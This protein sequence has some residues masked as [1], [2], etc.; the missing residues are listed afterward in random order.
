MEVSLLRLIVEELD[1]SRPSALVTV[2]ETK[3]S[4]PR[5]AGSAM[6]VRGDASIA[7]TVGGGRGEALAREA[8]QAVIESGRSRMI[9]VEML[10]EATLGSDMICG[11]TSGM[12]VEFVADRRTYGAAL[13]AA[14][15][16][17]R[18]LVLRSLCSEPFG[19]PFD[20]EPLLLD[21]ALAPRT[22]PALAF[23]R[24]LAESVLRSRKPSRDEEGRL[25]YDPL[26]PEEK[27]LILGGGHVGRA[28][29][30]LAVNLEFKVSV[31]D[32]RPEFVEASRF[33]GS[34][35]T[36]AGS[37]SEIVSSF[38]FDA[39][40]YTVI[41]T[42]GHLLD[43]ECVRAVLPKP[44][45]Y[46]GFIGSARK[47]RMILEQ[48]GT[49]GFD[50]VKVGALHAPIGLDIGAESPEEIAVSILA[51]IIAVRHDSTSGASLAEAR[52]ARRS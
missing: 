52:S 39:S 2:V 4:V 46:V 41:M 10:G 5:H 30:Q 25:F 3:G 21:E 27:L 36:L 45:R 34:V 8:A 32:D 43:L 23:D 11:G 49:E 37:F 28:L 1:A 22:G 17:E 13:S 35:A 47:T 7:G 16:G 19:K 40:T 15:W 31:G 38:A 26:M 18:S 24:A 42:R 29:A 51:E 9:R 33:P 48:L 12:L 50:A 14:G 20:S 44:G 6:L